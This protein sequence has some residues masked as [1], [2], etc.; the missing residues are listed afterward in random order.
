MN[1][2]TKICTHCGKYTHPQPQD[3]NHDTGYGHCIACL[4]KKSWYVFKTFDDKNIVLNMYYSR[5]SVN[6]DL[7]ADDSDPKV[8]ELYVDKKL[9][10]HVT[11]HLNTQEILRKI[12]A[13]YN[14]NL[15]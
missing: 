3:F 10:K 11:L 4:N 14:V 9:V 1:N 12:N 7:F 15:Q 5:P 2:R 6:Q 13:V 8:L